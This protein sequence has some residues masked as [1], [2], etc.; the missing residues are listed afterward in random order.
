MAC[1]AAWTEYFGAMLLFFAGA[2]VLITDL[3]Q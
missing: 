3:R 1:L 2:L